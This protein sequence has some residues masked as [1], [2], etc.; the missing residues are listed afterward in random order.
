MAKEAD[1]AGKLI[2]AARLCRS[3]RASLLKELGLYA[4]Q[5]TLIKILADN[6]GQSMGAL[7]ES[8]GVKPPTVT[9]MVSRMAD[10]GFLRRQNSDYDSRQSHVY[11]TESGLALL[12]EIE[13]SWRRASRIAFSK[14]TDK[15]EKRLRKILGKVLAGFAAPAT[16]PKRSATS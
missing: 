3:Q 2:L 5:D 6:D 11:L 8:L 10:Q 7:A 12:G 15:D 16:K 9:K 4:G 13:E 14:L 1:L